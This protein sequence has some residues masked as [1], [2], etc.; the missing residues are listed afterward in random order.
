MP[1]A[2][3]RHAEIAARAF[4]K[5]F[6]LRPPQVPVVRALRCAGAVVVPTKLLLTPRCLPFISDVSAVTVDVQ[7]FH[8]RMKDREPGIAD[9][10]L[11]LPAR[12]G[13]PEARFVVFVNPRE[14]EY[15]G[16]FTLAHELGHIVCGHFDLPGNFISTLQSIRLGASCLLEREADRFA[17]EFLVPIA[18]LKKLWSQEGIRNLLDLTEY[19]GASR[20]VVEI[21]LQR[22]GVYQC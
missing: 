10:I 9:A 6:G 17:A 20:T 7:R 18:E 15:R 4:A 19:F 3:L 12:F 2:R 21:Q 16:R 5:R 22:I 1:F 14:P 8:H 11:K 13:F